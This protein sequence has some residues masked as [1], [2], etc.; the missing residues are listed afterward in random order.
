MR[1]SE[2]HI[3]N[4]RVIENLTLN[5]R[6]MNIILGE[7]SGGKSTILKAL[8]LAI[9][10]YPPKLVLDE[11][12]FFR[13]EVGKPIK[14]ELKFTEIDDFIK[15]LE[16]KYADEV[17]NFKEGN[18]VSM[19]FTYAY[20]T[21]G[22]EFMYLTKS[23]TYN[24]SYPV[25]QSIP[26]QFIPTTRELRRGATTS[27]TILEKILT[28]AMNK[29]TPDQQNAIEQALR[30]AGNEIKN[31][32]ADEKRALDSTVKSVIGSGNVSF[33]IS[34]LEPSKI[35]KSVEICLND[36]SGSQAE[37]KGSG[38]Q[39]VLT[40][41]IFKLYMSLNLSS[42][43]LAIEEPELYLLPHAKRFLNRI[44]NEI[45]E[46][47][48]VFLTTHSTHFVNTGNCKDMILVRKVNNRASAVQISD[49][50]LSYDEDLRIMANLTSTAI[51]MFFARNVVLTETESERVSLPV[52]VNR[53]RNEDYVDKNGISFISFGSK[54]NI[55]PFL[56]FLN[57]FD[58]KTIVVIN[59]DGSYKIPT[60]ISS[61]TSKVISLENDFEHI[62]APHVSLEEICDVRKQ[63][64]DD[65]ITPDVIKNFASKEKISV[66][67]AKVNF[68]SSGVD[69]IKVIIRLSQVMKKTDLPE[70]LEL[71]NSLDEL[72]KKTSD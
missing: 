31:I 51:E 43:M 39:S 70:I 7:N 64:L 24:V 46:K 55:L 26:F 41:A 40:L 52:I 29:I 14:I 65:K 6:R 66:D 59:N 67:E 18:T 5:P 71:S 3:E 19:R 58:M 48:Q 20:G 34:S 47:N 42:T 27:A 16:T 11:N 33:E 12:D 56:K 72:N 63:I 62:I 9:N 60:E 23:G 17:S 15:G 57:K 28:K 2:V 69:K 30:T 1:L 49:N 35:L 8:D 68:M 53:I 21:R 32:L 37:L 50:D 54:S 13:R 10:S 45:S 38:V 25:Q 44:L 36:G 22:G 4:F 61:R